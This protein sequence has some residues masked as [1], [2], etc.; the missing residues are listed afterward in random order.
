MRLLVVNHHRSLVGGIETYLGAAIPALQARGHEILFLHEAEPNEGDSLI[1]L[2]PKCETLSGGGSLARVREWRPDLAYI[3]AAH[4]LELQTTLL[5]SYPTVGFAHGY[6][7][8]CISGSKTWQRGTARPCAKNFD[9][10]CLLQFHARGCGGRSPVTMLSDYARQANQLALF[11]RYDALITHGAQM[12]REY[13]A[14]G[15]AVDRL[16][17]LPHFVQQPAAAQKPHPLGDPVKLIYVG[18][19]DPLKGGHV[20]L[21]ALPSVANKLERAVDLQM[22]GA[23]PAGDEWKRIAESV[24]SHKIN[25]RFHGWLDREAKD[26]IVAQSNLLAAP[27][28]WPEP[29][30][31][32]GLE[33]SSLGVPAV[34]FNS[35]GVGAW[36][37]EGVNGHLADANPPTAE[38]LAGAIIKSLGNPV[39]YANLCSGALAV[40]GEFSV[41]RHIDALTGVFETVL[42]RR[43]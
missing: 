10:K 20:L 25:V 33:A 37:R 42:G 41:E 23:G 28:L 21:R 19:F 39:H 9:W 7:G 1:P 8:L 31:Q 43:K 11:K 18:R 6:Y 38:G 5:N 14:Q 16:F 13:L 35:G 2:P 4:D 29:F 36:L 32:V 40:W 24:T 22:I 15:L 34:A 30:G 27:S 17:T 3:H 12:R 26:A